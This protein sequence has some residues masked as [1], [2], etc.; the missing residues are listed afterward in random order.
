[1]HFDWREALPI[2]T[3]HLVLRAPHFDDV[4]RLVRLAGDETI[5][6]NLRDMPFP[7]TREH[8]SAFIGDVLASNETGEGL[9]LVM[10]RKADPSAMIGL[11]SFSGGPQAVETGY[12]L[13]KN[14]RGKG[15]A[16]EALDAV[17]TL[18]FR[19]E[20]IQ[21]VRA[22]VFADNPA[23]LHLLQK[24]GFKLSHEEDVLSRARGQR[25]RHLWLVRHR[26]DT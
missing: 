19:K 12:W 23:S 1:M 7:F 25:A 18:I 4:P 26:D 17:L 22:G 11:I 14:F 9:A 5:A 24:L 21:T 3:E 8:G 13:G 10:A 6:R 2:K 20:S 15:L 16:T